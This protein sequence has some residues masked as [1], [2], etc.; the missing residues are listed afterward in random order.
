MKTQMKENC[1]FKC[2]PQADYIAHNELLYMYFLEEATLF[3]MSSF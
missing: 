3:A 2:T 1:Q